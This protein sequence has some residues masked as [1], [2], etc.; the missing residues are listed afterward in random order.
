M[1]INIDNDVLVLSIINILSFSLGYILGKLR[2]ISGVSNSSQ[3]YFGGPGN[4]SNT[5]NKAKISIDDTKFVTEIKT[6]GLEKKYNNLGDKKVSNENIGNSI[7]KLKN[8]K[9]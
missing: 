9:G 6:E 3:A 5:N 7:N 8:M 1:I 2:P 4:Q